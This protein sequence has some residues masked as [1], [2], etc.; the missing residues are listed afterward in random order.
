MSMTHMMLADR[1]KELDSE[2]ALARQRVAE[3]L[4]AWE[5]A[6]EKH[7]DLKGRNGVG[8]STLY[9]SK[10][11]GSVEAR[12]QYATETMGP[13]LIEEAVSKASA[14]ALRARLDT[15]RDDVKVILQQ[16]TNA[17]SVGAFAREEM[18]L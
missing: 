12:K 17:Q 18:K 10:E 4:D 6:H 15:A 16:M 2:L 14:D 5:E 7:A 8:F 11:E 13:R 3:L 9:N 1:Y